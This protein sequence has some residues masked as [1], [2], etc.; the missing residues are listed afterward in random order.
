MPT[1]PL[2]A[3]ARHPR[4]IIKCYRLF[5]MGTSDEE[6]FE[7]G[8]SIADL[9]KCKQFH[10][11][12]LD[13]HTFYKTGKSLGIPEHI[14]KKMNEMFSDWKNGHVTTYNERHYNVVSAYALLLDGA[15]EGEMK[16]AGYTE[17]EIEK[18]K[19]FS[20]YVNAVS[21]SNS[22]VNFPTWNTCRNFMIQY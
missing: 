5:L 12:M 9:Q 18:A 15:D 14:S 7:A 10:Q 4:T 3:K 20:R 1:K 6:M 19:L 21:S 17:P 2:K 8:I 11:C 16:D 22:R 13:K